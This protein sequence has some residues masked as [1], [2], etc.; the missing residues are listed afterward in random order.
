MLIETCTTLDEAFVAASRI[1]KNW[2]NAV[3]DPTLDVWYSWCKR[4]L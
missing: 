3:G 1:A 4:Y 2:G